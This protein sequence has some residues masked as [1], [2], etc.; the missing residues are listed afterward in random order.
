MLCEKHFREIRVL[1]FS[2]LIR[3]YIDWV[4][5]TDEE[6]KDH[7]KS[8]TEYYKCE[9]DLHD[10][11]LLKKMMVILYSKPDLKLLNKIAF[12]NAIVKVLNQKS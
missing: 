1:Y 4:I 7:Y 12:N 8:F 2:N 10:F 11:I 5:N 9:I 6:P 3:M